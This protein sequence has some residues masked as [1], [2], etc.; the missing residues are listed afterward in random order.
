MNEQERKAFIEKIAGLI[1]SGLND[2]EI[3]EQLHPLLDKRMV[4]PLIELYISIIRDLLM[5]TEPK[6]QRPWPVRGLGKDNP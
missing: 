6:A 5:D 3:A 1:N 4:M 2:A